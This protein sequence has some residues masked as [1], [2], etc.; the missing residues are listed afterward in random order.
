MS[1]YTC[2]IVVAAGN[3]TRMGLSISKTLVTLNEK[4]AIFY[5]LQAMQL[6]DL[7]DEIVLVCRAQDRDKMEEIAKVFSKFK[8]VTI[9]GN[10]R[11]ESVFN[12]IMCASDMTTHY[13]IHDG[14]RALVTTYDIDKVMDAAFEYGAATLGTKVIDTIKV[15]NDD[16]SIQN[17]P[18]RTKLYA[19][20]TPQV[21][22]KEIYLQSINNGIKNSL[23]VTDDCSL[24]EQ[25]GYKV[26][27]V[28]GSTDN[29]KLT[30]QNDI[31]KAQIILEGRD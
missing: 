23:Q 2:A 10:S 20:Q 29:I 18:D 24:L 30:T 11:L 9:G 22:E 26:M 17:T 12:G 13:C 21:F 8:C 6:S 16:L 27:I 19:V 4:P 31:I 25:L 1:R 14:A 3:S 28:E 7:I 5:S 15:V